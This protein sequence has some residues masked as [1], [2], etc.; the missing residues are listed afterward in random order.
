[1]LERRVPTGCSA[2]EYKRTMMKKDVYI[3]LLTRYQYK[4]KKPATFTEGRFFEHIQI[5][6]KI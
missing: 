4:Q 1:M 6:L 3:T 5:S 2:D